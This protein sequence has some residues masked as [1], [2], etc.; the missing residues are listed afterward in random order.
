M[1][2]TDL[3]GELRSIEERLSY[4]QNEIEKI[5]PRTKEQQK[6]HY[7][8]ITALAGKH[9]IENREISALSAE[10]RKVLI[11]SLAYMMLMD[12]NPVDAGLLYL[13]RL[14]MG[15]HLNLSAEDIYKS[16]LEFDDKDMDWLCRNSG[17]Y[18]DSYLV[19]ALI[20]AHLSD[21]S[22]P[23]MLAA[24]SDTAQC[25]DYDREEIRVIA[26]AAKSKLMEQPD[27]L[28]DIPLPSK[29]R[30]SGRLADY[31]PH[32]W[33]IEQRK[34]CAELCLEERIFHDYM[35]IFSLTHL[36]FSEEY[37]Q[38]KKNRETKIRHSCVVQNH[39]MAGSVV[40]KGQTLLEYKLNTYNDKKEEKN[41]NDKYTRYLALEYNECTGTKK[42]TV[43]ASCDG[44]VYFL[45]TEK[46]VEEDWTKKYLTVYVVSFF[47]TYHDFVAW[48]QDNHQ[49]KVKE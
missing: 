17:E 21:G 45:E 16:G 36:A 12:N 25:M 47:D 11:V 33:I 13:T 9:P 8:K 6:K 3:Q 23:R 38:T 15:C 43:E 42:M 30:W 7:Q 22:S 2:L 41:T 34:E 26:Q 37:S 4:L 48:Y 27:L 1:N 28:L 18:R 19:E 31:I 49:T 32:E 14:S 10:N 5:K 35:G 20:L 44:I 29:K 24:I 39:V 40:K 46:T